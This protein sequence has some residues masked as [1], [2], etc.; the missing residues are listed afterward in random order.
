MA[1]PVLDYRLRGIAEAAFPWHG[2]LTQRNYLPLL[3]FYN[4]WKPPWEGIELELLHGSL[5]Q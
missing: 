1:V 5:L 3:W 2:T 4:P